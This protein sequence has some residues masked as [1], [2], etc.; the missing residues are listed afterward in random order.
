[1]V[2]LLSGTTVVRNKKRIRPPQVALSGTEPVTPTNLPFAHFLDQ[3]WLATD[4]A[5]QVSRASQTPADDDGRHQPA[6][7]VEGPSSS[8]T[9]S[10]AKRICTVTPIHRSVAGL[11]VKRSAL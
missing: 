2:T 3:E 11:H 9:R 8:S 5:G 10:R 7:R 4:T 6:R 1:M